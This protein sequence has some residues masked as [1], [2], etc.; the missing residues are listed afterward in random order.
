MKLPAIIDLLDAFDHPPAKKPIF[1]TRKDKHLL[2]EI[3]F[4][5]RLSAEGARPCLVVS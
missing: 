1:G 3:D 2:I 5:R 4:T